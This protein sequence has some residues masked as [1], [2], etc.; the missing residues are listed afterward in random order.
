MKKIFSLI[1][2]VLIAS[3]F[4]GQKEKCL[5]GL[6]EGTFVSTDQNTP[7]FKMVRK[8]GQQIE[9]DYNSEK[10]VSEIE[11]LNKTRYRI[12]MTDMD[13]EYE[14]LPTALVFTV[15]ECRND[16]HKV[17]TLFEQRKMTFE[18]KKIK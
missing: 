2:F 6:R 3:N 8:G 12:V 4:F 9:Y 11:W 14:S 18:F 15:V 5:T 7:G 1:A 17:E 10:I 13:E 16:I